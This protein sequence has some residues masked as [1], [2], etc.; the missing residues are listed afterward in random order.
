[1][2]DP[3]L[4]IESVLKGSLLSQDD[5]RIILAFIN[6]LDEETLAQFENDTDSGIMNNFMELQR[7]N[8]RR[9]SLEDYGAPRDDEAS[10]GLRNMNGNV[11][12][13][14]PSVFNRYNT[15]LKGYGGNVY[16]DTQKS[17]YSMAAAAV[18]AIGALSGSGAVFAATAAAQAGQTLMTNIYVRYAMT[19]VGTL[20]I[21]SGCV[22]AVR[23]FLSDRQVGQNKKLIDAMKKM[24]K[25]RNKLTTFFNETRVKILKDEEKAKKSAMTYMSRRPLDLANGGDVRTRMERLFS[26]V[27]LTDTAPM[28]AKILLLSNEQ[29]VS[30]TDDSNRPTY[31]SKSDLK[32][33]GEI[34]GMF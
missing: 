25:S 19:A 8:Q 26:T 34:S 3:T 11:L 4:D 12:Q 2:A 21:S 13:D 27:L 1:M 22:L 9:E 31:I 33:M 23:N 7:A 10:I 28:K 29:Y 24:A 16:D 32:L 15:A 6:E 5:L 30:L 20:G 14:N 17:N 18:G